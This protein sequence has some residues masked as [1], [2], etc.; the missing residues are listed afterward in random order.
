[1]LTRS[2]A[3]PPPGLGMLTRPEASSF[4]PLALV[5]WEEVEGMDGSSQ[6]A[7]KGTGTCRGS[8]AGSPVNVTVS[9]AM[10]TAVG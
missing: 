2:R 4:S 1:M 6:R 5:P 3:Q 7:R 9:K 10:D 8:G